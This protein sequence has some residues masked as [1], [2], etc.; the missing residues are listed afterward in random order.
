MLYNDMPNNAPLEHPWCSSMHYDL[1]Q[2]ESLPGTFTHKILVQSLATKPDH[3]GN[4]K[5]EVRRQ[6][7]LMSP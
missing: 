5:N 2:M 7:G 4:A 3:M 1:V 6:T